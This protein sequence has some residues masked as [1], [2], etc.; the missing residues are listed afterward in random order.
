VGTIGI[1]DFDRVD[2]SNLNRQVLHTV[3][4]IGK[5]K[6]E[7]AREAIARLNP[8]VRLI[9]FNEKLTPDNARDIVAEFDVV[10]DGTDNFRA[11]YLLNDAAFFAGKPYVFGAAVRTEGQAGVFF[12][13]G[14]G[15]CLRCLVPVPPTPDLVPT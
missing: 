14:G 15:P 2:S 8:D 10:L 3:A 4:N 13:G 1:V 6:T 9:T 11:K 12:P 5:P 7:S